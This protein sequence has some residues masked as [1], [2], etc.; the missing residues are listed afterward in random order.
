MRKALMG[1]LA[2]AAVAGTAGAAMAADLSPPLRPLAAAPLYTPVS[3]YNWTGGY[4]GVQGGFDWSS[5]STLFGGNTYPANENGGT[6][7]VYGGYNWQPAGNWVFGVDASVNYDSARGS[8]TSGGPLPLANSAGPTWNGLLRGRLGYA[9]D[10]F[11]IYGTAGGAMTGYSAS[12]TTPNGSGSATPFGWT[13][14]AGIEVAI[15]ER[16]SARLDYSYQNYG[17]FNVK[18][19]GTFAGGVPVKLSSNSLMAGIAYKF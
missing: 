7:G 18:G 5:A 1:I 8:A 10:R 12:T 14:G 6:A 4:L 13:V 15:T 2:L 16:W 19:S 9:W 3:A 17:T 11:M